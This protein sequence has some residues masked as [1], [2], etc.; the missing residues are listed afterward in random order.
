MVRRASPA[1]RSVPVAV[2]AAAAVLTGAFT[3]AEDPVARPPGKD[4]IEAHY[5]KHEFRI[6]M[7]DGVKLFT[8]VYVPKDHSQPWP[9]LLKRTPYDVAPYGVD[10]YPQTLGPSEL[11][12][13]D[14]YIFAYQ[15]VRGR[16]MSEGEWDEMRPIKTSKGPREADEAT[17]AWDTIDW[18]VK[19]V[20][21]NN[22]RVGMW[23]VS[24]PGFYTAAGMIDA[25]PALVAASPQAPVVD[26]YQGDDAFHNGA[27]FLAANFHFYLGFWPRRGSPGPPEALP[28]FDW[29]APDDY[30]FFLEMGPIANAD[31]LYFKGANAYWKPYETHTT[32]DAFWKARNLVPH[33]RRLPPAVLTVGGWFDAEDLQGP[34][35]AY[36]AI[37]ESSPSTWSALVMGPWG[38]GDWADTAGDRFGP[39]RFATP[40][41]SFFRESIELPFFA[42]HLKGTAAPNLP[43]AYVFDTGR[44]EW[45]MEV[46]WPPRGSKPRTLY[47]AP[48][49]TLTLEP[50]SGAGD[51]AFDEY[52]SDP[53]AP[54]PYL[55]YPARGMAHDYM[56]DDQRF[57]ATR[58]DVLVYRTQPLEEDL[59]A[60]GPV[61]VELSVST[62]GTDADFV[63][64]LIDVYPADFPDPPP[65]DDDDD[66][67]DAPEARRV[68]MGGFQHLVRGEPFRGKFRTSFEKPEPFP[69]GR[70]ERI[71]FTMPDVLHTFRR[72]HRIMVHIQSSW[73]PLVDLNPQTAVDIPNASPADFR[74]ATHRIHRGAGQQSSVTVLVVP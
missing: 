66:E 67:T 72:G 3:L 13:R 31:R 54:V 55:S 37:E 50:P 4:W 53:R 20:P 24:Y 8:A 12:A 6:P 28:R 34:L 38:H 46:A 21:G 25:H 9:I 10:R 7:R 65:T 42:H 35:R 49:G 39:L 43:E 68:R 74:K 15:D 27:F 45:R 23:G 61:A 44:N 11:F 56:S 1:T 71:A 33:L 58:P 40:T 30:A 22:G 17:D 16:F 69:P 73:F 26:L 36:R 29:L 57:A 59:T 18:L 5:T 19:H 51:D 14:N 52:V 62:T 32:Y 48:K 2:I 41:G 60:A 63:V 47:L 64:K 70:V